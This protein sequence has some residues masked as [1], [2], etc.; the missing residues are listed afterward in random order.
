MVEKVKNKVII[1]PEW[2]FNTYSVLIV[3]SSIDSKTTEIEVDLSN[4]K[5][6]DTEGIKFLYN[7]AKEGRKVIVKNP[8]EL[9]FRVLKILDIEDI[10]TEAINISE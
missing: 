2:V 5:I 4:V 10:F 1:K 9:M 8:P 3:K 6:V 7:L